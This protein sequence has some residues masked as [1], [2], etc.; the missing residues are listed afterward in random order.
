MVSDEGLELDPDNG[1]CLVI[2]RTLSIAAQEEESDQR[3]AIFHSKCT[4][5]NKVCSLIIDGGCCANVAS[6]TMVDKLKIKET[7]HPTP[8]VIQW[9]CQAKGIH[10]LTRLLLTFSIGN[11]YHESL[12]CNVVPMD[13]CHV[14]LGRLWQFDRKVLHDGYI[15]THTFVKDGK[16]LT[17]TPLKRDTTKH[18]NSL[19]SNTSC[20][21]HGIHDYDSIINSLFIDQ[22]ESPDLREMMLLNAN[23]DTSIRNESKHVLARS[24]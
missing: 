16:K 1:E 23:D 14:F 3:E 18:A 9:L 19:H 24:L 6:K 13:A 2:R 5:L 7:P 8:Y 10:V 21:K 11:T 22:Y 17:L 12:W 4:I 20:A 15:N